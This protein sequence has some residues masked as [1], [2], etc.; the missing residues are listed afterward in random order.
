M[1]PILNQVNPVHN[2]KPN[3]RSILILSSDQCLDLPSG[4]FPSDFSTQM[5]NAFIISPK[6]RRPPDV[7]N[8]EYVQ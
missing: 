4:L 3:L 8:S 5:M 1:N 7:E 6:Q 2:M